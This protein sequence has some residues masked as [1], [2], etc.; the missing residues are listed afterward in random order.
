MALFR[1]SPAAASLWLISLL[2]LG[3]KERA[4]ENVSSQN[5]VARPEVNVPI[6]QRTAFPAAFEGRWG[7]NPGDCVPDAPDAK[8]LVVIAG[9]TLRFYESRGKADEFTLHAPSEISATF[10]FSGEGQTWTKPMMF[11]LR[12]S[13]RQ[14]V[15]TETNPDLN[16]VYT[17]CGA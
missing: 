11:V 16:M 3:C 7:V 1:F 9:N 15:R 6:E 14:L 10:A 4:P 5:S 8:G 2:L 13:G 12:D 17:K